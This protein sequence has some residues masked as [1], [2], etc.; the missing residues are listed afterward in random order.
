MR[1]KREKVG[2]VGLVLVRSLVVSFL[3]RWSSSIA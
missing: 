3:M 2:E 1:M